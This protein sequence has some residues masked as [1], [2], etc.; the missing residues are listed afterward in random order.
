MIKITH[1]TSFTNLCRRLKNPRK[2]IHLLRIIPPKNMLPARKNLFNRVQKRTIRRSINHIKIIQKRLQAS[3]MMD[4]C[5]IHIKHILRPVLQQLRI[6]LHQ[7][8]QKRPKFIRFNTPFNPLRTE[9][10]IF[11][12]EQ[13]E[14]SLEIKVDSLWILINEIINYEFDRKIND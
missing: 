9:I 13:R 4:R 12:L 1:N 7:T 2:N 14:D 3:R 8:C 6:C 10:S 5:V 11:E